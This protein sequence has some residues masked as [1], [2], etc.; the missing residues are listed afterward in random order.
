VVKNV[1]EEYTASISREEGGSCIEK[2]AVSSYCEPKV[3]SSVYYM[4]F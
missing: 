3:N 4:N 1:L 2:D